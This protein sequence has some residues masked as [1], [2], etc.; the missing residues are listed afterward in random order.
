METGK[1]EAIVALGYPT[2]EPILPALVEWM[3][4]INWPVAR[5]LQPFL[6]S[7]GA[8]LAPHIR[9]VLETTD[10]VW[11]YWVMSCIV[12]EST[13]LRQLLNPEIQRLASSPT[14]G[15]SDEEVNAIARKILGQLS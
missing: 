8:P 14:P 13:E 6:A 9:R 10:D 1:A 7:I 15:E 12:A 4:D 11:K 5:V 2:V 3:K